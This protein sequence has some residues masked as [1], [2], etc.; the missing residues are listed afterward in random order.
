MN[1]KL[2]FKFFALVVMLFS[3]LTTSNNLFASTISTAHGHSGKIEYLERVLSDP[4]YYRA[5]GLEFSQSPSG[6]NWIHY[7]P[8]V[9]LLS[10]VQ[11]IAVVFR[12]GS[13]QTSITNIDIFD[14]ESRI[15]REAGL[16]LNGDKQ[17]YVLDMGE[18]KTIGAALGISIEVRTGVDAASSKVV[19]YSVAALWEP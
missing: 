12:T 5:W 6:P 16:D 7:S 10:K 18:Q 2:Y 15:H 4:P 13:A 17:L 14:G 1:I 8:Q 9:P 11:Y 19:I 3:L